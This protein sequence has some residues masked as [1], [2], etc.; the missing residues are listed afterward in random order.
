M[1][2]SSARSSQRF[3]PIL[4]I[5]AHPA[6]QTEKALFASFSFN[7]FLSP[8]QTMTK[9]ISRPLSL[10]SHNSDVLLI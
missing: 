4:A 6:P 10:L 2:S 8:I 1:T 5:V 7:G 9:R 3:L